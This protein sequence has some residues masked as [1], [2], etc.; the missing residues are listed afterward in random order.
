MKIKTF[1]SKALSVFVSVTL[2]TGQF[3]YL[4]NAY[5]QTAAALSAGKLIQEAKDIGRMHN[6]L[7]TDEG[8][9][10][11]YFPYMDNP[12]KAIEKA[13][14]DGVF[15]EGADSGANKSKI[16]QLGVEAIPTSTK[17]CERARDERLNR[18]NNL[19]PGTA[20]HAYILS[21]IE[22]DYQACLDEVCKKPANGT[23]AN[24]LEHHEYQFCMARQMLGNKDMRPNSYNT[25]IDQMIKK[26]NLRQNTFLS[27]LGLNDNLKDGQCVET[28][29]E[30]PGSK[31]S[32][33]CSSTR[34][35]GFV[36]HKKERATEH[37][38]YEEPFCGH[39]HPTLP[40]ELNLSKDKGSCD[41][42]YCPKLEHTYDP[43]RQTCTFY[44]N[45]KGGV[46]TCMEEY[47]AQFFTQAADCPDGFDLVKDP[48]NP[49]KYT[50]QQ[51]DHY[52]C[53]DES[54]T[55]EGFVV[56]YKPEGAFC[57]DQ[58]GSMLQHQAG[59]TPIEFDEK[60]K[61]QTYY[62]QEDESVSCTGKNDSVENCTLI[63]EECGLRETNPNAPNYGEC[64][65]SLKRYS[66]TEPS[67]TTTV[68][69]CGGAASFC[70]DGKCFSDNEMMCD[71]SLASV[72]RYEDEVCHEERNQDIQ[73]CGV[74]K[75][76]EMFPDDKCLERP[77]DFG[78]YLASQCPKN[79]PKVVELQVADNCN[80][81]NPSY[82]KSKYKYG[83]KHI[84]FGWEFGDDEDRI[85]SN[86]E[87]ACWDEW[88]HK[89]PLNDPQANSIGMT[90]HS[91]CYRLERK[92]NCEF[93]KKSCS[94]YSA[95]FPDQCVQ[96][97]Y[98]YSCSHEQIGND[99]QCTGD[100][101]NA[102]IAME[103]ARQ[104]GMYYGAG[105]S[106]QKVF[107]GEP[108]RCMHRS[109]YGLASK[110]CCNTN[111]VDPQPNSDVMSQFSSGKAQ[112][113]QAAVSVGSTFL[114]DNSMLQNESF[115]KAMD[116][117]V[118][119]YSVYSSVKAAYTLINNMAYTPWGLYLAIALMIYG[120]IMGKVACDE[121]DHN[122]SGRKRAGLCY[123]YG[124]PDCV[125]KWS[126][127]FASGCEQLQH[128][129]CC[130]N[131]KLARIINEQGK[132]Q[133]G[134]SLSDCSGFTFDQ[135]TKL[136]FSRIDLSEFVND[137]LTEAKANL[138][139]MGT[140]GELE[141]K[142]KNRVSGGTHS[143][144]QPPSYNDPATLRPH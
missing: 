102:M 42:W 37:W 107:E 21:E 92:D 24:S 70:I 6:S 3:T 119:A 64:L 63:G 46:A 111:V 98:V 55:V 106:G 16:M 108:A 128:N 59:C 50:C 68:T 87:F 88:S 35:S 48:M 127:G 29:V 89:T 11:E 141:D 57:Q 38:N 121:E 54:L 129:H 5:A 25:I 123:M 33:Q 134:I 96:E 115:Q 72:T 23:N 13:A 82:A 73:M 80:W 137:I 43:S 61:A 138:P 52:S 58:A 125:K 132:P 4:S 81:N 67:Q 12:E 30:V 17:V 124:S 100:F 2:L 75:I 85:P 47:R 31:S 7:A 113:V 60:G 40:I 41:V 39:T 118:D 142:I 103:A 130:F 45:A 71:G 136:D 65:S 9:I 28:L 32:K 133:L 86:S 99:E 84:P 20:E 83:C 53:N 51:F 1:L 93:K 109:S 122:V 101:V 94:S 26:D 78:Y 104:A 15:I 77:G 91:M 74:K 140:M 90:T 14:G 116:I 110:N 114:F 19:V 76:I 66:C 79:T 117:A 97:E 8:K 126:V 143:L 105:A 120:H 112:L 135:F 56:G 36:V 131:S 49:S 44:T 95:F 62:C 22:K 10:K 34:F 18:P 69:R 139:S 27:A 144:E